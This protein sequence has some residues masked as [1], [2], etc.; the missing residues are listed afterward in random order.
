[1]FLIVKRLKA[2]QGTAIAHF[3]Q[4]ERMVILSFFSSQTPPEKTYPPL[5]GE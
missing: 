4:K 2:N 3:Q 1:M 5:S